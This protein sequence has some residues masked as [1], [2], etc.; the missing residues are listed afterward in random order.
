MEGEGFVS[1][2][3]EEPLW[4]DASKVVAEEVGAYLAST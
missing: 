3:P 2:V 1:E 4:E